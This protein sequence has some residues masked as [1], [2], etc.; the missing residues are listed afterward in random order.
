M[1]QNVVSLHNLT[2]GDAVKFPFA[3]TDYQRYVFGDDRLAHRFGRELAKVFI[4]TLSSS[5]DDFAVA[6][7]S[8]T[9]PTATHRLRDH[10]VACLNRH[11]IANNASPALKIDFHTVGSDTKLR[12]GPP[13]NRR[14]AYHIDTERL[15][16]R[17][18]IVLADFRTG[19]AREDQIT[20]SFGGRGVTT[21]F[22][23][24]ASLDQSATTTAL[25]KF[26]SSVLSPSIK[27][28]ENIVQP[29]NFVMNECFVRFVLGR[30]YSEFCPFIRRQDDHFVRL[31][32]DHAINGCYHNDQEH[33]HNVQFL[34]WEVEARESM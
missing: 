34:L 31:L 2:G 7:L 20:S 32:L 21:I 14:N 27:E 8:E 9:V 18:L 19:Q 5:R 17:T 33:A 12:D 22:A 30:E 13:T 29:P 25:T 4:P 3:P 1:V 28:I 23:Y 24:L 16:N 26:L 10:F 6:V 11:L 15:Q